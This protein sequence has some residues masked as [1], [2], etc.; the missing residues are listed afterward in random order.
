MPQFTLKIDLGHILTLL[1]ITVSV[2]VAWGNLSAMKGNQVELQRQLSQVVERQI[3][4]RERQ[5]EIDTRLR[6]VEQLL[7]EYVRNTSP[8][9]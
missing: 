3:S 4:I 9:K 2:G 7:R 5:V 1:V 6:S 8:K